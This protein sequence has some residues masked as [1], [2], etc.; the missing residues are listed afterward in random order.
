MQILTTQTE[1]ERNWAKRIKDCED[2]EVIAGM[3]L[4][5]RYGYTRSGYDSLVVWIGSPPFFFVIMS[6]GAK[7]LFD[8]NLIQLNHLMSWISLIF[9]YW[10]C[11]K[12]Y[13]ITSENLL[14]LFS[15]LSLRKIILSKPYNSSNNTLK[16]L[17]ILVSSVETL[18]F[19][20]VFVIF[21]VLHQILTK[22]KF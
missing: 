15:S 4:M 5:T 22:S 8:E 13:F 16:F 10:F 12:I 17:F 3:L 14:S 6:K 2:R 9:Y 21:K 18:H 11:V 7:T 1:S 19:P 20:D